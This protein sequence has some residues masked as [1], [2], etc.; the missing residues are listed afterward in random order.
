[1]G[2]KHI[3]RRLGIPR[4]KLFNIFATHGNQVAASLP[5]ALHEAIAQDRI[6]RG[7]RVLLL[8]TSAG[9]SLGGMVI[10]Y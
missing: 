2:L 1:H 8:G 3:G 5:T 7:D 10:E 6:R 4:E 9:V